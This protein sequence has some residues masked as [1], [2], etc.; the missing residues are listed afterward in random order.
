MEKKKVNSDG[1]EGNNPDTNANESN[2]NIVDMDKALKQIAAAEIERKSVWNTDAIPLKK[3]TDSAEQAIS[4]DKKELT[5]AWRGIET[6]YMMDK[7]RISD[8]NPSGELRL[9]D[10]K[11]NSTTQISLL[12]K[13]LN[14]F[15][16]KA[17]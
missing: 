2:Q 8:K 5:K 3:F 12:D 1:I 13:V 4:E 14:F 15:T 11:R 9:E 17:K 6:S 7:S 16:K 10:L